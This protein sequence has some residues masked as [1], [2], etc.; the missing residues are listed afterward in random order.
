[1]KFTDE[2]VAAFPLRNPLPEL[3]RRNA[4]S[5]YSFNVVTEQLRRRRIVV[6]LVFL[7][8]YLIGSLLELI[9][10]TEFVV[11]DCQEAQ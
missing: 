5:K 2:M 7:L 9:G 1:M 6:F 11:T 4:W 3:L 8:T 10:P